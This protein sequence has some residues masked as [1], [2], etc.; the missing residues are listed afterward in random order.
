[1]ERWFA[2]SDELD[3]LVRSTF[4]DVHAELLREGPSFVPD[5]SREALAAIVVLDQFSRNMFR[6]TP[7]MFAVAPDGRQL[8]SRKDALDW[9]N[10]DSRGEAGVFD[11]LSKLAPPPPR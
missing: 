11:W 7:A 1:M 5:G 4:S 3:T 6:G 10:A 9:R 8:N 2:K